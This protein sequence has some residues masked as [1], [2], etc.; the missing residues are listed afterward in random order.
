VTTP[1]GENSYLYLECLDKVNIIVDENGF[2][3]S[4]YFDNDYY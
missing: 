3:A 2:K 1:R 4:G